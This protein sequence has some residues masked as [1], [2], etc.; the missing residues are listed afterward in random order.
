MYDCPDSYVPPDGLLID[1]RTTGLDIS[2]CMTKVREDHR[3]IDIVLIDSFHDYE[4]SWRDLVEGFQLIPD[5]GTLVVHDCLPPTVEVAQPKA[6]PVFW[7]GVTYQAFID[8]V[9]SHQNL[10]FYTVDTDLGCGIIHKQPQATP[11]SSNDTRAAALAEWE[12]NREDPCAAFLSFQTL[13]RTLVN[14]V[15]INEFLARNPKPAF[16]LLYS[17]LR[18]QKLA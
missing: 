3:C 2:E 10:E 4:C 13:K 9:S 7:C 8:F 14:M 15:S 11:I 16:R 5:E 18:F 1:Y 17:R 12:A 6:N